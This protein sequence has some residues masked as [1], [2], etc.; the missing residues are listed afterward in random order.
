MKR[1]TTPDFFLAC[2]N[3]PRVRPY[4]GG[5]C[6]GVVTMDPQ[7]WE[8]SVILEWPEGCIAFERIGKGVYSAHWAF[9]PKAPDIA[10][11]ARQALAYLFGRGAER[12]VGKTPHTFRHA[13]RAAQAAGMRHMFTC[14]GWSH[15]ALSRNEFL[16]KD[17]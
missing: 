15:S 1:A 3:H 6:Q 10:A 11:R 8:R 7:R 13:L 2:C 17:G 4:I 5:D 12:I 14:D 9:L 16:S